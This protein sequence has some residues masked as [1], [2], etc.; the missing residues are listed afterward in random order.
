MHLKDKTLRAYLDNE[1]P[2]RERRQAQSH[3]DGCSKCSGR[4]VAMGH[5]SQRT[6]VHLT[7]LEPGPHEMPRPARQAMRQL[8]D[9]ETPSMF[10]NL[11][12]RPVW[13]ALA[14]AAALAVSLTFQPVRVLA[15]NFLSLFRVQQIT[16]LPMDMNPFNATANEPTMAEAMGQM[17]S[18]SMVVTREGSD[19]QP[20]ADADAASQAAGFDVRSWQ[21]PVDP[22]EMTVEP[23][24]AFRFT[25]NQKQA[26]TLLDEAGRD[27]LK[28]PDEL[29]GVTVS[30]DLP[31]GVKTAY[32][33][34]RYV[35]SSDPDEPRSRELVGS[36]DC[37]L[38]VQVP[39]P[40]ITTEPDVDP[41]QIAE[42]GLR[43]LGMSE[44]EAASFSQTVDWA[45]T[46]VIPIPRHM[47]SY[48][49]IQVDGV[50]G[51]LLVQADEK[52]PS[53]TG[54]TIL[55]VRGGIIYAVIGYGDPAPG[56][57]LANDLN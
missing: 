5:Q 13:A 47:V 2:E 22:V 11:F 15:G 8:R 46:L 31:T 16:L 19:P 43:F 20:A 36:Q 50:D 21:H 6:A 10:N 48:D 4:L 24:P 51:N 3:L 7:A 28:V 17:L 9:K 45:S 37:L 39:S 30:A 44:E 14:L 55:W 1:L 32:G 54:Y 26:Q 40:A 35:K 29:D 41:A 12:K 18:K 38:L 34:C 53:Q 49:S 33:E 23:G 52:D 57:A 56:M 27:D 25:I 42:I